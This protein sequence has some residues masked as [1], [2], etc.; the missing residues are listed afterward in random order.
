[1]NNG[2]A[3]IYYVSKHFPESCHVLPKNDIL[4]NFEAS[5]QL[6]DKNLPSRVC[7]MQGVQSLGPCPAAKKEK[8]RRSG[9]P[10]FPKEKQTLQNASAPYA[11]GRAMQLSDDALMQL[12]RLATPIEPM[13]REP[14]LR[15]CAIELGRHPPASVGP[16]LVFRTAKSLQREFLGTAP[17]LADDDE[18]PSRRARRSKYR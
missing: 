16:G 8:A 17:Q 6:R 2:T 10:S 12:E 9:G 3:V 1:L 7:V 13:L 15:A 4:R 18:P 11:M 5:P 14:F